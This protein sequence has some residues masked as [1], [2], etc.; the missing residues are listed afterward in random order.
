[1]P[2]TL[3]Q[4]K[5]LAKKISINKKHPLQVKKVPYSSVRS[6]IRVGDGIGCRGGKIVSR[7]IRLF[8]GG[9]YDLSHWATIIRNTEI[10][11]SGRVQVFEFLG[12]GPRM[13]YLSQAYIEDHGSVFWVP[14]NCTPHQQEKFVELAAQLEADGTK[15][16][17]GSTWS[18]IFLPFI[19]SDIERFNCSESGWHLWL[20]SG[21]VKQKCD[22]KG[23]P[24]A[25]VPGDV[26]AWADAS[27][28]YELDMTC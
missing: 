16:D 15:Y 21:R 6:M 8:R 26:P 20:E 3:R 18:A 25:P 28:V 17:Y 23:R 11:A 12:G 2:Q 1:M 22:K 13:S 9:K 4:K 5:S 19:R 14:M 10:G 24:I 27:A 7:A